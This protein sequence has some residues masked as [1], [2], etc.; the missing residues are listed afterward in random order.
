MRLHLCWGNYE[1]PHHLDID[2]AKIA[3]VV[4]AAKPATILFEAANPRHEHE[5][6]AWREAT[7]P[8]DKIL[9][10][11]VIDSTCNYIEHPDLVAQRL[12]RFAEIVGP[13]RVVA[14]TDCGFGTW[15]GFGSVDP[16][17]CW[18]KLAVLAEGAA[19][20]E[21]RGMS[22]HTP[23]GPVT[24]SRR[25]SFWVGVSDRVEGPLGTVLRGPMYVEW[26]A[27]ASDAA[28]GPPWVLVHGGGGQG[29]DYLTTPD[30]R[31]GWSRL[32]VEQGHTVYVVDRPGHGRS[33]FHPDVLGPMGPPNGGAGA[34]PDLRATRRGPRLA[35]DGRATHAMA[36]RA[37]ARGPGV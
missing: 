14:G 33:P 2:V 32:L 36:G 15:S 8:A 12:G 35:S 19:A 21:R 9:A 18:A 34:P 31:L 17:I 4:L 1:G 7:I 13:E 16:D 20:G 24:T 27:P 10:P 29:T 3:D 37:R 5:W 22:R 23:S 6:A 28:S 26:E 30:G 25:G 11:G